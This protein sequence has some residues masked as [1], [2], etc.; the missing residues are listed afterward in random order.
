MSKKSGLFIVKN[1]LGDGLIKYKT[2][3]NMDA[4]PGADFNAKKKVGMQLIM[5]IVQGSSKSGVVPPI[6]TGNLRGSGSVF[7]GSELV[8]DTR[9]F[10]G[11]G[12]PCTSTSAKPSEVTVGFNTSYAAM[13]HENT[14]NPGPVSTQSGDVGNKFV[15]LHLQADAKA[16]LQ[17]Y[18]DS[19]KNEV[20]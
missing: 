11:V 1:T 10:V 7:V 19:I 16:C 3:I 15:Q 18:A 6:L 2:K 8:F 9:G 4:S 5:W 20:V 13:M 17:M 12:T 14:W